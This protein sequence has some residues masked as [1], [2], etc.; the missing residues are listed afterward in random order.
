[1]DD[2]EIV[3]WLIG[4][5][6]FIVVPFWRIFARAGFKPV[7][8]LLALIPGGILILLWV[9]AFAKWPAFTEEKKE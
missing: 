8:S 7:F 6:I 1:M 3:P 2:F 4:A 5:A 9:I